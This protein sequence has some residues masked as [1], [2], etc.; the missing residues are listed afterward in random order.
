MLPVIVILKPKFVATEPVVVT[1]S[2]KDK[3][4]LVPSKLKAEPVIEVTP[5]KTPADPLKGP[6]LIV[7]PLMTAPV[8]FPEVVKDAALMADPV[9]VEVPLKVEPLTVEDAVR[10]ATL[11]VEPE[12]VVTPETVVAVRVA[13]FIRSY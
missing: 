12:K 8:M 6:I 9:I 1:M 11:T 10:L 3:L 5:V 13:V 4:P 2:L 7:E